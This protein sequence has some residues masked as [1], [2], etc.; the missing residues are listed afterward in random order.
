ML[1]S[2]RPHRQQP[3]RLRHLWDP[4][5]KNTGVGC[6]FLLQCMKV[7]SEREVAESCP[8]PSDLMD[9]SLPGSSVHGLFQARVLECRAIAFS[10]NNRS[11]HLFCQVLFWVI[12]TYYFLQSSQEPYEEGNMFSPFYRWG[13]WGRGKLSNFL[14]V[15]KL[16][17]GKDELRPDNASLNQCCLNSSVMQPLGLNAAPYEWG[18][19]QFLWGVSV[20]AVISCFS[21]VWLLQSY[22]P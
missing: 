18:K 6:H 16:V 20:C 17:T 14:K 7:K 10:N 1:Q 8:T 15:M 4:P 19:H 2:V 11:T 22:G 9:C 13:N 3:T 12:Y 21:C 5:G